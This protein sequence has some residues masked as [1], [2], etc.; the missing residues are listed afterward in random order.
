MMKLVR[1]PSNCSKQV[2]VTA[3]YHFSVDSFAPLLVRRGD[4]TDSFVSTMHATRAAATRW[5]PAARA[6]KQSSPPRTSHGYLSLKLISVSLCV[7]PFP[8]KKPDH[9]TFPMPDVTSFWGQ[10][11]NASQS[12]PFPTLV[13]TARSTCGMTVKQ[14]LRQTCDANM[15][16]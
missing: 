15:A 13:D 5:R 3:H 2:C 1:H 10:A 7:S 8:N 11:C 12:R 6:T 9:L 4:M 14:R 16:L